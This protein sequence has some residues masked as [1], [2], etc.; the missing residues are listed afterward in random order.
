MYGLE[1]M[2]NNPLIDYI[3]Q[4]GITRPYKVD[5]CNFVFVLTN[6]CSEERS[7]TI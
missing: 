1:V 3:I 7:I 6:V 4:R 5:N 2:R